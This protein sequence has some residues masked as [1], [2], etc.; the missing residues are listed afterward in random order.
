V[1]DK[2]L[3]SSDVPVLVVPP[4][5]HVAPALDGVVVA[6]DGSR[7][8]HAALAVARELAQ[9]SGGQVRLLHVVDASIGWGANGGAPKGL[10]EGLARAAERDL[11]AVATGEDRWDVRQGKVVD[12]ILEFAEDT[13]CEV[14]A[15]ATHGRSGRVRL[16]LG[17]VTDMVLRAADRPVLVVPAR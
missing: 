10:A 15:M 17:S 9:L 7:G 11:E 5:S 16:D 1:A 6:L 12:T 14:V 3:R 8:A 4:G 2:V 13:G